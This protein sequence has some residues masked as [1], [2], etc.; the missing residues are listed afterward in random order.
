VT[1]DFAP[2]IRLDEGLLNN[3]LYLQKSLSLSRVIRT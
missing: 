1:Q 2:E 3:I